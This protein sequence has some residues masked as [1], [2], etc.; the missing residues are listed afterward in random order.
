MGM[1]HAVLGTVGNNS[2][3]C[4]AL[5][6]KTGHYIVTLDVQQGLPLC[7]TSFVI[8]GMLH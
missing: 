1:S 2:S 5:D 3:R 4:V 8:I 7:K 6:G